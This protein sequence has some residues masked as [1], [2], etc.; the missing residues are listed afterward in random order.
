MIELNFD[1]FIPAFLAVLIYALV[2]FKWQM[3]T[4]LCGDENSRGKRGHIMFFVIPPPPRFSSFVLL[5]GHLHWSL[6]NEHEDI[7]FCGYMY[8]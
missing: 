7:N 3:R 1:S 4:V 2:T 5:L 6:L 8:I